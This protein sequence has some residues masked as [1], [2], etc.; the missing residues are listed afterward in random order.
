MRFRGLFQGKDSIQNHL[1]SAQFQERP[2]LLAE[3]ARLRSLAF[4]R[5]MWK[6]LAQMVK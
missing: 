1:D 6:T 3:L 5:P 4:N 2:Y